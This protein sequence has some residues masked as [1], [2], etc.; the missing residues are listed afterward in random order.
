M[1]DWHSERPLLARIKV[2]D[3]LI[4]HVVNQLHGLTKK[5]IEIVKSQTR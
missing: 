5:K 1:L 4:D 2:T 3:C